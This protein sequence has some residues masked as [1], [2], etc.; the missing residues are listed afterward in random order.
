MRR[1]ARVVVLVA[2]AW[3]AIV[4][5]VQLDELDTTRVWRLGAVRFRGND[6]VRSADLRRVMATTTRPWFAVWRSRPE[7]DPEA[8]GTDLER[9]RRLYES[10]GY[11]H[12][13]VTHDIE[14]PAEGD[15]VTVVVY[16]EEGPA[17]HVERVDVTF[18]GTEPPGTEKATL[19]AA[20]PIGA[21]RVF[22]EEDYE[23][24]RAALRAWYREH[25]YAR[26]EV[27]KQADVDL[28]TNT[29]VVAYHVT[30]GP[31][32]TF[33]DVRIEGTE[34]IDPEIVRRE[35][36]FTAGAPF[37][38][39]LLDLTRAQIARLSL[40]EII[41][42]DEEP[43]ADD[44]VD[45]VIH[46]RDAPSR[47]VRLGVGYDTEEQV[48]GLASWRSYNFLGGA[49]QLG[50]SAR[51]SQIERAVIADFL[52]PHFPGSANRSRLFLSQVRDDEETYVLD[53]SRVSPRVELNAGRRVSGYV[54]YRFDYDVLTDVPSAVRRVL[55]GSAPHDSFVSGFGLGADW[56]HTDDLIDPSRG[57]V[58]GG[59]VEPV[60]EAL[61]SDFSFLR[62][63][64]QGR[65]Y[66]PLVGR[67]SAAARVRVGTSQPFAGTPEIPLPERFYSGGINSNRGYG[68]RRIG[69]LVDD[70][71]IGGRSLAEASFELRHPITES[72]GASIFL[73][74]SQ[75]SLKSFRLP[76]DDLQYAAGFGVSYKSPVGPIRVDFGFPV[77]P[78]PEDARW[79]IQ[80]SVG[81][82]F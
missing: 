40:F 55:P 64:A 29:A 21:G 47:E 11:Y 53:R 57:W 63:S 24:G 51:I 37:R 41:R 26:V 17:V 79:Q 65:I 33:G 1:L 38:Q 32:C 34:K 70:D 66:Q 14:L 5:A 25:G 30:S 46:L 4:R 68:R 13:R 72:F 15:V 45:V 6:A 78:P 35:V 28:D 69:P 44:R 31:P 80:V 48:R 3:R 18:T 73:D 76:F 62:M 75:V 23:K 67:L 7:L 60:A 49:R 43:A 22:K 8:L 61:G 16:V 77:D 12:V 42:L 56:D 10:R 27:T 50:F 71:P 59:T 36:A 39:S 2:A 81:A 52:Q 82:A 19:L 9:V 58:V 20:L 54:F 74:G